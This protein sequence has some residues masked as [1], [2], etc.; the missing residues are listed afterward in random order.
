MTNPDTDPHRAR[1]AAAAEAI[2]ARGE[3]PTLAAVR[4]EL[5]GGSFSTISPALRAWKAQQARTDEPVGEPL[6]ESLQEA[7]AAG[8]AQIWTAALELASER[9]SAERTAL[10]AAR[11]EADAAVAEAAAT[12]DELAAELEATQGAAQTAGAH[13]A[14]VET[15]LREALANEQA[16]ARTAETALAVAEALADERQAEIDRAQSRHRDLVARLEPAPTEDE[17]QSSS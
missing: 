7:A 17:T 16:R 3:N 8:A 6:P 5:G 11:A 12:A 14:A 15:E 9:L 1:I 4:A 13:H 2:A 10:D